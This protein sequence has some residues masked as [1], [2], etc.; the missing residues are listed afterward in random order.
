[1]KFNIYR[2]NNS[3][4][5]WRLVSRNGRIIADSGE[6]YKGK[7]GAIKAT[8][9]MLSLLFDESVPIYQVEK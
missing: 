1:M 3:E 2:D 9:K 6:G 8:R 7:S 5:R 4:W